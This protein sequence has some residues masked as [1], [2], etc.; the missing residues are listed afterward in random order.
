MVY[1]DS[2]LYTCVIF[3]LNLLHTLLANLLQH[4]KVTVKIELDQLL[5]HVKERF[6]EVLLPV[7]TVT[8]LEMFGKGNCSYVYVLRAQNNG[9]SQVIF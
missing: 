7:E 6:A 9:L 4:R 2:L 8:K 1:G 5:F 3:I